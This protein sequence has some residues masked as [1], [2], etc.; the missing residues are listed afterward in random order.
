MKFLKKGDIVDREKVPI[1]DYRKLIKSLE[2]VE[3]AKSRRGFLRIVA[4]VKIILLQLELGEPA[5]SF[6]DVFRD[7]FSGSSGMNPLESIIATKIHGS[8]SLKQEKSIDSRQYYEYVDNSNS[9][10]YTDKK[11][12]IQWE[13]K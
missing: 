12:I 7:I 8:F 13:E 3:E 9:S 1:S 5:P 11:H 4:N 6:S 2:Y 10:A